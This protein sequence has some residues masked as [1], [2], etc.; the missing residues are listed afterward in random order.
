MC[1]PVCY[2]ITVFLFPTHSA[3]EIEYKFIKEYQM[4]Y[5]ENLLKGRET[6][7]KSPYKQSHNIEQLLPYST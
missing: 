6:D 3:G 1:I 2:V 4:I 5:R 7:P